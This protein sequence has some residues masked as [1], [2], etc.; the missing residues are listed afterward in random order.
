MAWTLGMTM[1]LSEL[2]RRSEGKTG[3]DYVRAR[4]DA[5]NHLYCWC[6]DTKETRWP[7]VNRHLW[8]I[9]AMYFGGDCFLAGWPGAS[10][11]QKIWQYK[12][13]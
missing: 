7:M 5:L 6:E 8:R 2:E 1:H 10:P 11:H 3:L 4:I 13:P 9:S 12:Q